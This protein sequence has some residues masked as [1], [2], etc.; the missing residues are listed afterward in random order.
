MIAKY[1]VEYERDSGIFGKMWIFGAAYSTKKE[2]QDASVRIKKHRK[3][4]VRII[5]MAAYQKAVKK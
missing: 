5:T 4:R 1:V 3:S 2:A